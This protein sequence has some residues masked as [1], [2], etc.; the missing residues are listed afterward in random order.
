MG[1]KQGIKQ[2]ISMLTY[3]MDGVNKRAVKL[4]KSFDDV[5]KILNSRNT[6]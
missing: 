1:K 3:K 2:S 4:K 5:N 6:K